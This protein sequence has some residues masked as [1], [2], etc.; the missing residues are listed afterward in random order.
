MT[1]R[2][3]RALGNERSARE[4]LRAVAREQAA[5]RPPAGH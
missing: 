2:K 4:E 3:L 5:W 1:M